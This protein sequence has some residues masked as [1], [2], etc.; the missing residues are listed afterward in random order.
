MQSYIYFLLKKIRM[1]LNHS[2]GEVFPDNHNKEIFKQLL[3]LQTTFFDNIPFK[4]RD[5]FL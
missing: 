4:Q 5:Y 3:C 1:G 2:P